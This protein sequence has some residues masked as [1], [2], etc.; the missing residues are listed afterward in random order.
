MFTQL[1]QPHPCRQV[2]LDKGTR[3]LG[4]ESL[5]TVSSGANTGRPVHVQADIAAASMGRLARMQPHARTYW[6]ALWPG[7]AG[8]GALRCH[9]SRHGLRGT[10]EGDEKPVPRRVNLV[11][12]PR[13]ARLTE[14]ASVRRQ[15]LSVLGARALA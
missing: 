1:S 11:P 12:L 9:G 10:L 7:I 8:Q 6:Q 5:S 13:L 14:Q 2:V 3:R 4:Q 15:D